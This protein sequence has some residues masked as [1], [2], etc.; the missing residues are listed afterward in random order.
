MGHLDTVYPLG[1]LDSMP[2]MERKGSLKGPGVLDMKSGFA[3]ALTA[4]EALHQESAMPPIRLTLL[5]NSD[6]ETGSATSRPLIEHLAKQHDL[7]LCLEPGLPDGSLKTWRKGTGSFQI[8]AHG[9]ASH[10]GSEPQLGVN[11]ILEVIHQIRAL[12]PL[13]DH[14]QGT[15]LNV[16]I[17][18]GGTRSNVIPDYCYAKVDA[19]VETAQEQA[20]LS[21]AMQ[22][23]EPKLQG[24][25][26]EV[27]GGWNRPPMPR[28]SLM[29][30]TFQRAH[31]IA[32]RLG[33]QLTEGGTGGGSDAN[34]IAPLG[35]PVLDGLG[36][37]GVGAHSEN[38]TVERESLP[39]RAALIAA[40]ITDWHAQE[41]APNP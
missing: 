24:A 6:E 7:V 11:A 22:N 20:R 30:K 26:L 16:G 29:R 23:L 5:C 10:A 31:H 13:E 3:I 17:I 38:E 35:I 15:T 33:I 41:P 32:S 37:I 39:R 27:L 36:A 21:A 4:I 8:K 14:D 9:K 2:W 18:R 25:A 1:T 12:I 40:L 28:N 34:F 19:R